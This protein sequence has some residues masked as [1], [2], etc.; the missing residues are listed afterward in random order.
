MH[1][2]DAQSWIDFPVRLRIAHAISLKL[3]LSLKTVDLS[4]RLQGINPTN[5][6]VAS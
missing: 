3:K 5:S 4:R 6:V 1:K 2:V